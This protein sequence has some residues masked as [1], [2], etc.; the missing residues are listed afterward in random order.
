MKKCLAIFTCGDHVMII[1]F[2]LF[3]LYIYFDYL[4]AYIVLFYTRGISCALVASTF[5]R[6]C[7][8]RFYGD[9]CVSSILIPLIILLFFFLSQCIL[10]C[11]SYKTYIS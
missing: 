5:E 4:L 11:V 1:Y 7:K 3:I 6:I 2:V 10:F 8:T 9:V